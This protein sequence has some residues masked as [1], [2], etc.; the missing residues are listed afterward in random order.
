MRTKR[1]K[2]VSIPNW[3]VALMLILFALFCLDAGITFALF[4]LSILADVGL[5]V[6]QNIGSFYATVMFVASFTIF[7]VWLKRKTSFL[8]NS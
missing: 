8:R 3:F 7:V 4:C 6:S 2:V 5:L 1:S